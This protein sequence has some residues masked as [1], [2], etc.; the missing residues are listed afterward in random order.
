[1]QRAGVPGPIRAF[2]DLRHAS[3][4]N[5]AAAGEHP[6]ALMTRAGHSSMGTTEGYLHLA[7]TVFRDEAAR[8]ERRLLGDPGLSTEPSTDLGVPEAP[9]RSRARSTTRNR[10]A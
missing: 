2:H 9:R 6:V 5:G 1:M 8:L 10:S 7:G 4:T 3:L